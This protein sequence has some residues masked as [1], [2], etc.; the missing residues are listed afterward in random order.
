MPEVE[1]HYDLS[2]AAKYGT[3][4]NGNG[5]VTKELNHGVNSIGSAM[6]RFANKMC[7][8]NKI[9]ARKEEKENKTKKGTEKLAPFVCQ[10][11]FNTSEPIPPGTTNVNGDII[12]NQTE[13]VDS[14]QKLLDCKTAGLMCKHLQ[15]YMNE[16]NNC[17]INIP[18]STCVAIHLGKLHWDNVDD[19]EAFSLLVCYHWGALQAE[20]FDNGNN[21]AMS[22]HLGAT[23]G[24]G[25]TKEDVKKATKLALLAPSSINTLGKQLV[26]FSIVCK[27]YLVNNLRLS[28][29]YE[30]G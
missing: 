24:N 5:T 25:I 11:I 14:Y 28:R 18:L 20:S 2:E 16:E 4:M 21:D 3:T 15:H 26:I 7:K 19:P 9:E 1:I 23:E 22:M 30:P 6:T 8:W 13:V 17:S 12:M 27:A 10:M 29:V